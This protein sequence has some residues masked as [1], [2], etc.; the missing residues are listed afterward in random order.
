M[1]DYL[2]ISKYFCFRRHRSVQHTTGIRLIEPTPTHLLV[3]LLVSTE[4]PCLN[5]TQRKAI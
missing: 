4:Q 3:F 5:G 1:I 2:Q